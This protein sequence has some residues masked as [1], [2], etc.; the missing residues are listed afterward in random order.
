MFT[1]LFKKSHDPYELGGRWY[2]VTVS[3]AGAILASDIEGVTIASSRINL[4]L[5]YKII[6]NF[7][8][9]D[10][11][12]TRDITFGRGSGVGQTGG[13]NYISLPSTI[14]MA[15][16]SPSFDYYIRCIK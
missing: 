12:P 2:K 15:A 13:K 8:V 1:K 7:I 14:N 3:S 16:M 11:I 6:D 10:G 4:P 9:Y 5:P